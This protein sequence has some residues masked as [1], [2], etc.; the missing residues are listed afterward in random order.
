[1]LLM[2]LSLTGDDYQ[3][4]QKYFERKKKMIKFTMLALKPPKIWLL[5]VNIQLEK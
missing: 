2:I 1:M 4:N 5:F 3:P